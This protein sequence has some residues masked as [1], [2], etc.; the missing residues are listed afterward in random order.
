S[1]AQR[2]LPGRAA[3]QQPD[4]GQESVP[5]GLPDRGRGRGGGVSAGGTRTANARAAPARPRTATSAQPVLNEPVR[6]RTQ[7][8]A[9]GPTMAPMKLMLLLKPNA[10]PS[11]S[12]RTSLASSAY[13]APQIDQQKK[14]ATNR[15]TASPG[16]D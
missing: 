2:G 7:P 11:S 14:A 13:T 8:V 12:G 6:S 15:A 1:S 16:I 4:R 10:V 5:S 3:G 9:V